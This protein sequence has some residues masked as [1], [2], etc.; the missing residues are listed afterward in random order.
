MPPEK[1][2]EKVKGFVSKAGN[3]FDTCL[4]FEDD[5]IQFD[6]DNPGITPANET[7]GN[8]DETPFY[9]E[10]G[11]TSLP[12]ADDFYAAMAG[13]F[14]VDMA[15]EEAEQTAGMNFLDEFAGQRE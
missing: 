4:K 5:R 3:Q 2:K 10:L 15:A 7:S 8:G 14:A 1:T 11:D 12:T 9:E 13:E 6:F